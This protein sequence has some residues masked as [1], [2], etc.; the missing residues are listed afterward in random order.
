[1]YRI[2]FAAAVG[3]TAAACNG[4]KAPENI[5]LNRAVETL[6]SMY[7]H[8]GVEDCSLLRENYPSDVDYRATYLAS[9][10][11]E[12]QNF[13]S[14]QLSHRQHVPAWNIYILHW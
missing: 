6:D 3:I 11:P 9:D 12:F 14:C 7:S 8:Y 1:M 10:A 13:A 4:S 2:F 5:S